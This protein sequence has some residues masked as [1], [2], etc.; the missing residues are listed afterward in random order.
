MDQETTAGFCS[1]SQ[2]RDALAYFTHTSSC[3]KQCTHQ[4]RTHVQP[5]T[6]VIISVAMVVVVVVV[7]V[8]A[9]EYDLQTRYQ[10]SSRAVHVVKGLSKTGLNHT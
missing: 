8:G 5:D 2:V 9:V 10:L 6:H 7:V 4:S 3:G 1:S